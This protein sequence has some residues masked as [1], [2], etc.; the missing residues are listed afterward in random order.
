[1]K[2]RKLLAGLGGLTASL[3]LGLG[4]GAFSS[5]STS[6]SVSVD[7][8][9]DDRAFL[10]MEP[11]ADP[12]IDGDSTLRSSSDGRT[13]WF[14]L[15]GYDPGENLNAEGLGKES[16]Y[17]FHDLL[18]IENQGTQPVEVYSAYA[19]EKLT[20]LALVQDSGILR[21]DPPVIDVGD[22]IDVGLQIDTHGS[23]IG[24]SN[25]GLT[26]IADQPDE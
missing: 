7:V 8:S 17:E 5:V 12:G 25:E 23:S 19:G 26:I 18:R 21:D 15:P 22:S 20:N 24:K 6:R 16:V 4:S 2:R 11:R 10:R 14:S 13:V 1:M 3:S 9:D